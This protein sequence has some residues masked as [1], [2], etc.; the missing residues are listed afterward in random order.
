MGKGR[1]LVLYALSVCK[2]S[3]RRGCY[4]S[5]PFYYD[6]TIFVMST[7]YKHTLWYHYLF[8]VITQKVTRLS[9]FSYMR[10]IVTLIPGMV[11]SNL[12]GARLMLTLVSEFFAICAGHD[13]YT[14]SAEWLQHTIKQYKLACK[15]KSESVSLHI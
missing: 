7:A 13:C 5:V 15:R 6:T 10:S 14:F 1:A 2:F 12:Q 9:F 3:A 8:F 4:R 11:F